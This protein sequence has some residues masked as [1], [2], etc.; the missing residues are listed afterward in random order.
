M[1][2]SPLG[3]VREWLEHARST[4][5]EN[6]DAMVLATA[7]CA[8]IPSARVVLCRGI[9]DEGIRFFTNYESR[10]GRELAANPSAALVFFWPTL[11]WQVRLEGVVAPL[12]PAESDAY[13]RGRPRE[14]QLAA[15]ASPQSRVI[16][17]LDDVRQRANDLA[18]N[19]QGHEVPRPPFWGGYVFRPHAIEL[20]T[21]GEHRL[22]ERR[23]F[24]LAEG[25]WA[26]SCLG[27]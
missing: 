11:R 18:R 6:A 25:R 1:I 23:L 20:W 13:F 17:S 7:T 9:D 3:Q 10:K 16:T 2:L 22:H 5:G 24:M 21:G 27:P 14:S 26:E 19:Y 8:G 15:W 4:E 12:P